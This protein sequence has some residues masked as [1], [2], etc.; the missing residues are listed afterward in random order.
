MSLDELEYNYIFPIENILVHFGLVC[1]GLSCP[2]LIQKAYTAENVY[3]QLKE[4]A[5]FFLNDTKRNKL[6]GVN[7]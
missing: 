5:K 7:R 4:N 6:E 3:S 2:K 1:A